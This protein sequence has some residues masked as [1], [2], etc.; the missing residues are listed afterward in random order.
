[1]K[2]ILIFHHMGLLTGQP[3]LARHHLKILGYEHGDSIFDPEQDVILCMCHSLHNAPLVELVTPTQT[4]KSLSR[5]LRRKDDYM[6]HVCFTA[7]TI[8][9]GIATLSTTSQG[10]ITEIMTPKPAILFDGAKVA[11]YSVPGLGLVELLERQ[12]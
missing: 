11:F 12:Q 9:E 5:L 7:P 3:D 8:S 1:M 10:R 2:P 6:Y 4:N